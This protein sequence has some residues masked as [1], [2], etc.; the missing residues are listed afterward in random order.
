M[1][2]SRRRKNNR[3][4]IM[5]QRQI[6][7]ISVIAVLAIWLL[8]MTVYSISRL[9]Y[10]K[11]YEGVSLNGQ[12]ISGMTE[13]ELRDLLPGMIDL[14]QVYDITIEIGDETAE[15]STL[16]LSPFPAV[17]SMVRTAFDCGRTKKGLGRLSEISDL[18]KNP[19][20]IPYML[21]FD[22]TELQKTVDR[23]S[24]NLDVHAADNKLEIMQDSVH[25]TRGTPGKGIDYEDVR[26]AITQCILN[27]KD[28]V[29][30]DL[31][32]ISPEE[33]S[34]DFLERYTYREPMDATYS[35]QD[36]KLIFTESHPGIKF[37]EGDVK[38]AIKDAEGAKEFNIP[39][40]I[41]QPKVSTESLRQSI[42]GDVLGTHSTDFAS[43]SSD[44]A[45]NIELAC[46]KIDG[47]VL[48][49]GEEFSY[50]DVV[51][52]RT[53]EAGFRM[54]N[55]Y[56]NGTSQPG[57][58]GGVCQVSSTMLHAVVKADLE[59]TYR[60]NHSLPVSY[61][62]MGTDATVSYDDIDFKF[63]NTYSTP[64]EISA[65]WEGRKNVITIRGT[66]PHPERKIEIVSE[67]TGTIEP[68]VVQKYDS[69][70]PAGKTK[71]EE[72]G[73][74]GS[75]YVA[76]K[77]VYENGKEVSRE[78]LFKSSYKG[79]DRVELI[80]TGAPDA[81]PTPKPTPKPSPKATATPKPSP[82]ATATPKPS[83]AATPKPTKTPDAEPEGDD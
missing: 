11:V 50:N 44:R 75:T 8:S 79:K 12:N 72:V 73:S 41:T 60:R 23:L 4:K 64:I 21:T 47:Y 54:A 56:V 42:L 18:K 81:T 61:V 22:E 26:S 57:I 9:T 53:E 37:D 59:I 58:G 52:P 69:S 40:K 49:P 62:P 16:A 70:I 45:Y 83:K 51:G 67:R 78:E 28:H 7:K 24:R 32:E 65:E 38:R 76:H 55:V 25:I 80:G 17:D 74:K 5:K 10:D 1:S 20:N 39:A 63:K 36:H 33:I 77:V 34:I 68:K 48:A 66:N 82:K 15:I 30:V 14:S 29:K 46:R 71:V 3:K 19:V 43:S 31:K 2:A 6:A 35:I 13:K 27:K